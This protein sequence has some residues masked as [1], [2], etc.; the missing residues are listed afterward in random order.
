MSMVISYNFMNF[1]S[2]CLRRK[3]A[4]L[5]VKFLIRLIHRGVIGS[6]EVEVLSG[7]LAV[8]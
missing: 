4:L 3:V 7:I 8:D 6:F 1:L 5:E 2:L